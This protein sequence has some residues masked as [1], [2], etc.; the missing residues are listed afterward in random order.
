M[1]L[2][3][4]GHATRLSVG[5][6]TFS[7]KTSV[8]VLDPSSPSCRLLHVVTTCFGSYAQAFLYNH[9]HSGLLTPTKGVEAKT[10]EAPA[11]RPFAIFDGSNIVTVV[12]LGSVQGE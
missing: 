12:C 5:G 9:V 1:E 7:S 2:E 11:E 6:L 4:R 10:L 3:P 8:R